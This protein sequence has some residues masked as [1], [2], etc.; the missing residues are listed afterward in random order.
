MLVLS[1]F[2]DG[3]KAGSV[4]VSAEDIERHVDSWIKANQKTFDGWIAEALKAAQ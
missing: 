4:L 2:L 1:Y 3:D